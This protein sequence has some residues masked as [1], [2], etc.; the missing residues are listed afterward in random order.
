MENRSGRTPSTRSS[1]SFALVIQA[2]PPKPP[3]RAIDDG[4]LDSTGELARL[5]RAVLNAPGVDERDFELAAGDAPRAEA[6]QTRAVRAAREQGWM[7]SYVGFIGRADALAL[8][9]RN[10]ARQW[11][12]ACEVP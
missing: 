4:V 5:E 1:W 11:R 2:P 9:M 10:D 8:S 3:N 7:A 12:D 6:L